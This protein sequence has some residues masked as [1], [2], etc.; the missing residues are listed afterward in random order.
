MEGKNNACCWKKKYLEVLKEV[1]NYKNNENIKNLAYY[2]AQTYGTSYLNNFKQIKD[3][4]NQE[5]IEADLI[6]PLSILPVFLN[7]RI[8]YKDFNAYGLIPTNNFF[9][10]WEKGINEHGSSFN[11]DYIVKTFNGKDTT[12]LEIIMPGEG[13]NG[14]VPGTLMNY[15]NKTNTTEI[16]TCA[17]KNIIIE[18]G[19]AKITLL[20][21]KNINLKKSRIIHNSMSNELHTHTFEAENSKH[22]NDLLFK[23]NLEKEQF[24]NLTVFYYAGRVGPWRIVVE[25]KDEDLEEE[26]LEE[27]VEVA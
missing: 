20:F 16:Y 26:N 18:T 12:E 11:V 3:D 7:Y 9:T 13:I 24:D 4:K 19:I 25:E 21:P 5:I 6:L 15:N 22:S 8:E 14:M 10:E 27:E 23:N 2:T 17:V 1:N